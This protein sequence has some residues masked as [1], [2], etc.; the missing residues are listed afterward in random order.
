MTIALWCILAAGVLPYVFVA[1]TGVPNAAGKSRWGKGY[2]NREPREYLA[3]LDG[4]RR[5]A[6][7]GEA[8]SHEAFAPF[9]AAV[10]V[11]QYVHADQAWIDRLALAFI[12]FRVLYGALYLGDK[13]NPRSLA[14]FGGIGCVLGLFILAART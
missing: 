8:N 6:R 9:A 14:W 5:R 7:A 13:A 12:G 1:L 2:D 3:G 10:L 4:W 11:A